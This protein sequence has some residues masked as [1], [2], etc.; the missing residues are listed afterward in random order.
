MVPNAAIWII[1][2]DNRFL[3]WLMVK[4]IM[5]TDIGIMEI[6]KYRNTRTPFWEYSRPK[7]L[8]NQPPKNIKAATA[9]TATSNDNSKARRQ[10]RPRL[11]ESYALSANRDCEKL[12]GIMAS[13]ILNIQAI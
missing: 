6:H 1:I 2:K 7:T 11:A 8:K 5:L 12:L 9:G 13:T 10:F 3:T 4:K